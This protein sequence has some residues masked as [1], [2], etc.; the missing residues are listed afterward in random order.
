MLGIQVLLEQNDMSNYLTQPY[1]LLN[2]FGF[3][4]LTNQDKAPGTKWTLDLS[5]YSA[6]LA[7]RKQPRRSPPFTACCESNMLKHH[8][9]PQKPLGLGYGVSMEKKS[10]ALPFRML[11]HREPVTAPIHTMN[12]NRLRGYLPPGPGYLCF[13]KITELQNYVKIYFRKSNLPVYLQI[14]IM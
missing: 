6:C 5:A 11:H 4:K 2:Y 10:F 9:R 1:V 7:A 12:T 13:W 8:V 14:A 3:S